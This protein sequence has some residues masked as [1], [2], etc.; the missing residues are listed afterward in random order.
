MSWLFRYRIGNRNTNPTK[1][2]LGSYP[3]LS[4]VN[5]RKKREEEA[6]TKPPIV[7]QGKVYSGPTY[8]KVSV[9]VLE[10]LVMLE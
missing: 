10:L 9:N 1:L 2:V 7:E 5:A 3:D 4:L 6:K 8:D